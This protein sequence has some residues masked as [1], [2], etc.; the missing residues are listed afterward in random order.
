MTSVASVRDS[1]G[2]CR[3]GQGP[4]LPAPSPKPFLASLPPFHSSCFR[5]SLLTAPTSKRLDSRCPTLGALLILGC[6]A[7]PWEDPSLGLSSLTRPAAPPAPTPPQSHQLTSTAAPR[8]FL[9]ETQTSTRAGATWA[10][11][12]ALSPHSSPPVSHP[13]P[14]STKMPLASLSALFQTFAETS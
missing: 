7:S 4:S 14:S 10:S 6:P 5:S 13:N 1:F 3:S 2:V 11:W 9:G 8:S 12:K